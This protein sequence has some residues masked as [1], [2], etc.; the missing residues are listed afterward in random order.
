VG[1]GDLAG[2]LQA[3]AVT[4]DARLALDRGDLVGVLRVEF[5]VLQ[6]I[7]ARDAWEGGVRHLLGVEDRLIGHLAVGLLGQGASGGLAAAACEGG[8]VD[9]GEQAVIEALLVLLDARVVV[10]LSALEIA[11]E[12]EAAH[13]TGDEVRLGGAFEEELGAVTLL[14]VAIVAG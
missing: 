10:A 2:Q 9:E 13:V 8:A 14:G 7:A 11:A 3:A 4:R 6:R 5:G 1:T 12:E